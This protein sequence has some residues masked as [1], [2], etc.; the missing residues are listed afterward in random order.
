[1]PAIGRV[2]LVSRA[3]RDLNVFEFLGGD[4]RGV[5]A[6]VG[7]T[8][9]LVVAGVL[10]PPQNSDASENGIQVPFGDGLIALGLSDAHSP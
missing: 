8:Y 7:L 3:K 1:M 10:T 9:G 5:D 6:L 4:D 2:L